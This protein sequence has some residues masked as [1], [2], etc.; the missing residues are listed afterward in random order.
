VLRDGASTQYGS[1]AIAGVVNLVLK[2]GEFSPFL[3]TNVGQYRPGKGYENDGTTT[4]INGG[5]GLKLGRGSLSLFGQG[6]EP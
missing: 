2:E 1:D 4:D 5:V 3:N 6:D